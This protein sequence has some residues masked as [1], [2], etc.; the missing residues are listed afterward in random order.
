MPDRPST[1]GDEQQAD[2]VHQPGP[3]E[4]PVDVPAAL[5]QQPADAE[6]LAERFDRLG[7]VDLGRTGHDV[8]DLLLPKGR[9][10]RSGRRSWT[11]CGR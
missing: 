2:L 11:S 1:P 7:Q 8:G 5:Q 4:R 9:P 3:E 6:V 10:S